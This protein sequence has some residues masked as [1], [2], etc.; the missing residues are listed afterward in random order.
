MKILVSGNVFLKISKKSVAILKF[1]FSNSDPAQSLEKSVICLFFMK[2]P[3]CQMQNCFCNNLY[4]KLK[5][6]ILKKYC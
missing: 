1:Q 3:C 2:Y 6:A 4:V 5:S